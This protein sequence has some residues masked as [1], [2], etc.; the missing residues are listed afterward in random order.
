MKVS[1][2]PD[3]AAQDGTAQSAVDAQRQ[4][5]LLGQ[6]FSTEMLQQIS[7]TEEML[8]QTVD[9]KVAEAAALGGDGLMR[10]MFGEDMGII[11]AALETLV[12]TF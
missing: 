10:Q 7:V 12:Y 2:E 3:D 8:Q 9:Q 6:M 4:V 11:S 5:E 1:A